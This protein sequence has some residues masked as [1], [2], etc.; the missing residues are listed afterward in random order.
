MEAFTDDVPTGW[1]ANNKKLVSK[2]NAQGRVHSGNWSVSMEDGAVLSQDI[3]VEAGCYYKLHFFAHGEGA[4]VGLT[5]KVKFLDAM[6]QE[7]PGLLIYVRQQD[8]ETSN[9]SFSHYHGI[10]TVAPEGTILARIEF[11]VIAEG[12]QALDLDDVSFSVD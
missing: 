8:I 7:S 3:P 5:A 1:T 11:N 10:T 4:Q 6:N 9:R 12:H 2:N